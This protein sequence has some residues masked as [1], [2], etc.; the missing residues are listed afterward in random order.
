MGGDSAVDAAREQGPPWG[1]QPNRGQL[2]E[3]EENTFLGLYLWS[4]GL[5]YLILPF[6]FK[7][8]N[9]EAKV[10]LYIVLKSK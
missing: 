10:M 7:W 1:P 5:G 2:W 6:L 3:S 9:G 8:N 4:E